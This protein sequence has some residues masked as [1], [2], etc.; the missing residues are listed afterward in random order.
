LRLERQNPAKF[1]KM[2]GTYGAEEVPGCR[3]PPPGDGTRRRLRG[4]EEVLGD[5]VV[6]ERADWKRRRP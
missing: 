1:W 4:K 3:H 2:R 5:D 6:V